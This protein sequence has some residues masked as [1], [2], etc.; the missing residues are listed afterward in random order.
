MMQVTRAQQSSRV[1]RLPPGQGQEG[2]SE[3]G[4]QAGL[5]TWPLPPSKASLYLALGVGGG[6]AGPT[7]PE[8]GGSAS[9]HA[10][11]RGLTGARRECDVRE[12]RSGGPGHWPLTWLPAAD[13]ETTPEQWP[14]LRGGASPTGNQ[15][16]S[17]PHLCTSC[18]FSCLRRLCCS[19]LAAVSFSSSDTRFSR[20]TTLGVTQGCQNRETRQPASPANCSG[21]RVHCAGAGPSQSRRSSMRGDRGKEEECWED[22]GDGRDGRRSLW[23]NE[24]QEEHVV[25][26]RRTVGEACVGN[27]SQEEHVGGVGGMRGRRSTRGGREDGRRST[28]GDGRRW[29]CAV[30]PL[31]Q[32]GCRGNPAPLALWSAP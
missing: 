27:R 23:G 4:T 13:E 18:R 21:G 15:D 2:F 29:P 1:T 22:R 20:N 11:L 8:R 12:P 32:Q 28:W 9:L 7:A 14:R 17:P 5:P 6:G 25:G 24:R 30:T 31:P 16:Q 26:M 19:P 10:F 3:S